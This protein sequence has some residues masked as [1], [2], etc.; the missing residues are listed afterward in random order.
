VYIGLAVNS[1]TSSDLAS[2]SFDNVSVTNPCNCV[3]T[4]VS[5][6]IRLHH[7]S[8]RRHLLVAFLVDLTAG[9]FRATRRN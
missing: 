7:D 5:R 4:A 6:G 3:E 8:R 2:S 9:I 1:G